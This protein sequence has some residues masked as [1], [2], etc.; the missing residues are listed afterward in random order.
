MGMI[1]S[2]NDLLDAVKEKPVKKIALASPEDDGII[3]LVKNAME[4]RIAEF[5]LVGDAVKIR[6]LLRKEEV[7]E[8]SFEI[9][10]AY[11]HKEAAEK[12][13]SLVVEGKATVVMKGELHTAVFLKA[14]LDKERG[15][16]TGNLISQI[17]V[18]EKVEGKGLLM[19]TDC[20]MNIAPTLEEKKQIIENAVELAVKLGYAKPKVAVLSA[21]EV[22]NPVMQDSIDAAVLSKMA[23]RG[24]IEHAIVDGPFALDNAISVIAAKQKKIGGEVAGRADIVLVPNLQVGNVIHKGLTY[25]AN[26]KVGAAV[27]GAKVPIV[28]TSRA[29]TTDTKLY[30]IAIATYIS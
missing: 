5:I 24:Q 11:S 26:K 22:V 30:S 15:L 14:V 6:E 21:V 27:M 4:I 25:L 18:T 10:H 1:M 16:R 20:A 3:K 17:T 2:L 13:V 8:A 28:M 19:F 12:A 29:D 23:D 7:D 9:H